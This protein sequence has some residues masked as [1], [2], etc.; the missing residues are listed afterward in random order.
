MIKYKRRN[1]YK[2]TLYEDYHYALGIK[3]LQPIITKPIE[4]NRKGIITIHK[5]YSWDGPSG[6]TIDTPNFMRGSL[7]H[8]ALYQ[9]MRAG[10]LSQSARE[11]ADKVLYSICREAGM[12]KLRALF[13]Y[14]GVRF[15]GRSSTQDV[16]EAP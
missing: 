12:S 9:L 5:G 15:G 2:Y 3:F 13:V 10:L 11:L 6:P 14:Y 1:I 16:F 7:V 8:D 4:I